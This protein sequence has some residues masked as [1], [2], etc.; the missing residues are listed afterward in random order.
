MSDI[1]SGDPAS[2]AG[3]GPEHGGT[4][5]IFR[6]TLSLLLLGMI[7]GWWA[8]L[9][10][11][12]AEGRIRDPMTAAGGI[13]VIVLLLLMLTVPYRVVVHNAFQRVDFDG[14]RCYQLGATDTDLL[15]HCPDTPPPRNKVVE[16]RDRR[17]RRM[18]VVESIFSRR[19]E[20]RAPR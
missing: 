7:A 11:R 6:V 9:A 18:P 13:L 5:R 8:L 20:A 4:W 15:L 2:L 16:A 12:P 19:E 3:L 17:L 1:N 14:Q 10:G